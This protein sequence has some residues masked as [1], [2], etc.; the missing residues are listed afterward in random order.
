MNFIMR[1]ALKGGPLKI[2]M[3]GANDYTPDLTKVK[4][5]GKMPPNPLDKSMGQFQ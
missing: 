1:G 3:S 4:T 2:P 5:H